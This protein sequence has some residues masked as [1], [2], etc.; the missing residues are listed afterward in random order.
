MTETKRLIYGLFGFRMPRTTPKYI[1][2]DKRKRWKEEDMEKAI[3]VVRGKKMGTQKAAKNF[4]VPRT[5]L[6]T[7]SK[8]RDLT[9]AQASRTKLGRKPYLGEEIEEELVLYLLIMEQKFFGCTSGDLRRM[10]Y[11]LSVRNGLQI[12][13]KSNEAGRAWVDLFLKRHKGRLSLRKTCGTSFARALGFNKENVQNFFTVL[14]EAYDKHKFTAERIYNVDETGLSIVQSKV[15]HVIGRKGKRQIAA[16]TSAE[17]GSTITVIVCMSASGHFVPPLVIFPRTNMAQVLMKGCPPGSIGRAHPSGWVQSN[18]FTEWFAHFIEKVVPKEESP[19]LLIL[20]GHYS[21]VRNVDVIDMARTNH[22]TIISLPPHSTHKLQPLDK[23]FMGPL[24]SYYSEE[25][26]Q[27]LRHTNRPV[28]PYDIMELFENAY[29]QVQSGETAVNGFRTTGIFPLNRNIFSDADFIVSENEAEKTC[30]RTP[31]TSDLTLTEPSTS[32]ASPPVQACPPTTQ[33]VLPGTTMQVSPFQIAPVP[34]IKKK[35]TN[36]GRKAAGSCVITGTPYKEVLSVS[37]NKS[38]AN[39]GKKRLTFED[40]RG[41]NENKNSHQMKRSTVSLAQ[42]GG[43][44]STSGTAPTRGKGPSKRD[45]LSSE[46]EDDFALLDPPLDDGDSDPE[47]PQGDYPGDK[48]ASCMFCEGLFSEDSKGELWVM[49]FV[50][51]MWAHSDC[52]GAEKDVYICD[53]CK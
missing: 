50:C 24:K 35:V 49:C 25:V 19:V 36:R 33:Q 20:D 46:S 4:N 10:A 14:E 31:Q 43:R 21:H 9:P 5:T 45:R 27:W 30:N 44:A 39:K 18:L 38:A 34:I 51:N 3:T 37:V 8:K 16:L 2:K 22:V 13:F 32:S 1:A 11:Q 12:S 15:A 26:R 40:N 53:F 41:T 17:R 47:I 29:L 6:Q 42:T 23:T 48:D 7:L 28:T 52:A